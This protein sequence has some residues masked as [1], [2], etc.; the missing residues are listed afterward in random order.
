M[1]AR[2]CGTRGMVR[3]G[4]KSSAWGRPLRERTTRR[5]FAA[6]ASRSSRAWNGLTPHGNP[7]LCAFA[8]AWHWAGSGMGSPTR[9]PSALRLCLR[10]ALGRQWNGLTPNGNS[11]LCTSACAWHWATSCEIRYVFTRH[12]C[13]CSEAL[14][15]NKVWV[16]IPMKEVRPPLGGDSAHPLPRLHR[17]WARRCRMCAGTELTPATSA[18]RLGS[19][20]PRLHRDWAHPSH[21]CAATHRLAAQ[22][23]SM[24]RRRTAKMFPNAIQIST[25]DG[26]QSARRRTPLQI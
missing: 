23:T 14:Y 7:L 13:F 9:Q 17:G 19:P 2:A 12:L 5:G 6:A 18:P 1:S 26:S 16:K 8:C 4:V 22:V 10:M 20:L 11:L 15:N 3:C 21:V 25:P 24:K